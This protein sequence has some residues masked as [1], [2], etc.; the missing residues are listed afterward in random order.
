MRYL[1]EYQKNFKP[2]VNCKEA[3]KHQSIHALYKSSENKTW[4]K[5]KENNLSAFLGRNN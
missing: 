1:E 5:V 4:V 3:L 2:L